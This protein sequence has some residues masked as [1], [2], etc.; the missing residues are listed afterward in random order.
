MDI[1][2]LQKQNKHTRRKLKLMPEKP[3]KPDARKSKVA[4][5]PGDIPE[6]TVRVGELAKAAK[7]TNPHV[8]GVL[9]VLVAAMLIDRVEAY[10]SAALS[11]LRHQTGSADWE[12]HDV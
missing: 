4:D 8:F 5:A 7:L 12:K 6:L 9:N 11:W 3:V 2:P 1:G 10:E